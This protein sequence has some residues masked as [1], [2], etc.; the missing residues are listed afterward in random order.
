EI[1]PVQSGAERGPDRGLAPV[2]GTR[3]LCS[4]L[5]GRVRDD[6]VGVGELG[7]EP[8]TALPEGTRVRQHGLD[9]VE[10][11]PGQRAQVQRYREVDLALDEQIGIERERVGHWGESPSAGSWNSSAYTRPRRSSGTLSGSTSFWSAMP[12]DKASTAIA[13][14]SAGS[15]N[16]LPNAVVRSRISS[17]T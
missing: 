7:G 15:G 3:D 1:E 13:I 11:R 8:H 6:V 16:E 14:W 10:L 9:V 2:L 4:G 17:T 12:F 5:G